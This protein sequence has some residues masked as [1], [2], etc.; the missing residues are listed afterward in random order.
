MRVLIASSIAPQAMDDLAREHELVLAVGA[1]EHELAEAI[2]GSHALVFRSGVDISAGVLDRADSLRLVIRAGSG[3]D[4][5]DLARLATMKLR[6][7]RIPGPGAT[8]VAELA[9]AMMLSLARNL[10]WADREWRAGHWVKSQANGR[11]LTGRVLGIVGA[12][13]IGRRTGALGSAW[14]M[15][16]L[17]CV[18]RPNSTI[19]RA[20]AADGIRCTT[21]DD[22]ISNS[23]FVS[24]H[25][26]LQESTRN[27]ID[28]VA[29]MRR[30]SILV[31]LSRGGVV[32]ETALR[33]ALLSG[34]LAGAGLDVHAHEGDGRISPLADLE[35]VVLTPHIGA[36]TLDSQAEIGRLIVECLRHPVP[37]DELLP[38]LP[39]NFTVI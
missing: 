27:L 34:H 19:D 35:Q 16:V 38:G 14:G 6:V 2:A 8:A 28:A 10:Q 37:D 7:V 26:P 13:N 1:S 20:L 25:V 22:V 5:I 15:D 3:Y 11:L 36:S 29:S 9:F 23:D 4:N 12:G 18:E 31:N 32:D 39:A 30:G 21:F 33:D 24:V 17:G